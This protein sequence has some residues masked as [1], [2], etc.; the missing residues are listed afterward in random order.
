M[1]GRPP[2]TITMWPNSL[3]DAFHP[4]QMR[5]STTKPDPTP[6]PK[7]R[8]MAL[9]APLALPAQTSPRAAALASFS[10]RTGSPHAS[11]SSFPKGKFLQPRL[12]L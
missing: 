11:D 3:A 4:V 5:P 10:T 6:V 1:Q 7:V 2:F 12:L 8:I 9:D